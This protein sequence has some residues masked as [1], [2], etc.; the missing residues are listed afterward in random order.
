MDSHHS[1]HGSLGHD[2][3]QG[4]RCD[5]HEADGQHCVLRLLTS[6]GSSRERCWTER[7]L[8]QVVACVCIDRRICDNIRFKQEEESFGILDHQLIF[9]VGVRGLFHVDRR[10]ELP[11]HLRRADAPGI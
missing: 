5:S 7:R 11:Y 2:G 3:E 1:S 8:P 4:R 6:G 10:S 9:W